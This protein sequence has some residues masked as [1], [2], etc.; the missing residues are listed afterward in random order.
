MS[1]VLNTVSEWCSKMLVTSSA[2]PRQSLP[3]TQRTIAESSA[4]DLS[5]VL[6]RVDLGNAPKRAP[7]SRVLLPNFKETVPISVG[8]AIQN[9]LDKVNPSGT[10][11]CGWHIAVASVDAVMMEMSNGA[12]AHD[13]VPCSGWQC[14]FCSFM[15]DD[16]DAED[17][18]EACWHCGVPR[19]CDAQSR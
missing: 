15:Q 13:Y 3:H 18:D 5:T 19:R 14:E 10:G 16:E 4:V 11:C 9:V 2:V 1:Q 6:G 8:Q 12:C 17:E 7:K